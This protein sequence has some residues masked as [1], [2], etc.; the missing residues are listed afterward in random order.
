[1]KKD[2]N[3]QTS[4]VSEQ[5]I[6][7]FN[8]TSVKVGQNPNNKTGIVINSSAGVVR[9]IDW[10]K[11]LL[12]E[13][14]DQ[15][16]AKAYKRWRELGENVQVIDCTEFKVMKENGE[17]NKSATI[18]KM[19]RANIEKSEIARSLGIRYQQVYNV[20]KKDEEFE[21]ELA[22]IESEEVTA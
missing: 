4:L 5:V 21:A 13:F 20:L 3:I 8:I 12:L 10:E 11:S 19:H 17:I 14:S 16:S 18:R 6:S 9:G 1:M 15:K 7:K 2:Q 22:E